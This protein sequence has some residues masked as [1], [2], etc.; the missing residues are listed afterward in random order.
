M[1]MTYSILGIKL[2]NKNNILQR[3]W[4]NHSPVVYDHIK[5]NDLIDEHIKKDLMS[6]DTRAMLAQRLN[7]KNNAFGIICIDD[8]ETDRVWKAQEEKLVY[9]FCNNFFAPIVAISRAINTVEK[10]NKPS[11]AELDAIRL[12]AQG[13]SYKRIAAQLNKSIRTIEFQLRNARAKTGAINQTE[14][15]RICQHW[16]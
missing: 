11:P 6:L 14:L 16:L 3:V 13:L 8:L 5:K 15:V 12:A 4:R 10:N 9:E 1:T 2:P 7:D